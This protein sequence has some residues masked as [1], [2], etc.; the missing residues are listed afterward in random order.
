LGL[1][2]KCRILVSCFVSRGIEKYPAVRK[3]V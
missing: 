1:G 3:T 2:T